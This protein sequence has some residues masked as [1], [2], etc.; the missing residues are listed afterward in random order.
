MARFDLSQYE[1]VESRLVRFWESYPGGRIATELVSAEGGRYIVK[2]SIFA[3]TSDGVPTSTGY[4]E[5]TIGSSPVNKTSALEN[6]ETSAIG[7]ALAN[8]TFQAKG[9]PRPSREEMDKAAREVAGRKV[10]VEARSDQITAEQIAA[11]REVA[12][13]NGLEGAALRDAVAELVGR[14]VQAFTDLSTDEGQR[15]LAE[16][17]GS[18]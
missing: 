5:E 17:K 4:A 11:I 3:D 18:N 14:S 8:W 13:E 15:V 10:T 9:A 12:A 7:R 16:M 2:A 6:C 1:T